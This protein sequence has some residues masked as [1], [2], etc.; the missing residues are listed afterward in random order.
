MENTMKKMNMNK[1]YVLEEKNI[2]VILK[3]NK[4]P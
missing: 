4:I 1:H 3:L 2:A